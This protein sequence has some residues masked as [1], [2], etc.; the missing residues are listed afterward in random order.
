MGVFSLGG[1]SPQIHA[2][3]LV[4]RA[5]RDTT[6]RY[7]VFGY[8]AH[9]HFGWPFKTIRLTIKTAT[10]LSHNPDIPEDIGLG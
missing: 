5:T 8:G 2:G 3:F 10:T 7:Q 4:P 6:R 9:T 1:W